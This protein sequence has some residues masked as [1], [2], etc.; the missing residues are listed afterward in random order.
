MLERVIASVARV[1]VIGGF[2]LGVTVS[3]LSILKLEAVVA[4]EPRKPTWTVVEVVLLV[5]VPYLTTTLLPL[6]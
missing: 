4:G 3:V 1:P 6:C 5:M 2:Q